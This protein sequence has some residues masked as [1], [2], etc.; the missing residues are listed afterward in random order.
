[1]ARIFTDGFETRSFENFWAVNTGLGNFGGGRIDGLC[2]VALTAVIKIE[3]N[4]EFYIRFAYNIRSNQSS[5]RE[6]FTIR[7][8]NDQSVL[9][10]RWGRYIGV[11]AYLDGNATPI[12]TSAI[13]RALG[14]T[15][16]EVHF[17]YGSGGLLEARA[18]GV[19]LFDPYA[20]N[21]KPAGRA[22]TLGYLIWANGYFDL[23]DI[24]INDTNGGKDNSW[25]G[26]GHTVGLLPNANGEVI[27][28]EQ[29]TTQSNQSNYQLVDDRPGNTT[30]YVQSDQAGQR[31][32]YQIPDY[33]FNQN[34]TIQRVWVTAKARES[35][36]DS[37][38]LALGLKSNGQEHFDAGQPLT[39]DWD[40]R[41]SV[42]YWKKNPGTN[43]DWTHS[44]I[45][46]L[47]VGVKIV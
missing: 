16:F 27:E 20:G 34:D 10:L 38:A 23:D 33:S 22:D 46:A 1:M 42:G 26:D 29:V 3:S 4:T 35:A 13:Q 41:Q 15:I 47:Q 24:A 6:R 45:N 44:D 28:F 40:L 11:A 14:W 17:R 31:D 32:L 8:A 19:P 43:A 21:T 37:D 9:G 30:D 2:I 25:C 12:A 36:A 18:N 39:P 5:E 7:D